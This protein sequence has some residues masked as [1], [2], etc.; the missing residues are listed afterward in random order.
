MTC[1]RSHSTSVAVRPGRRAPVFFHCIEKPMKQLKISTENRQLCSKPATGHRSSH[2][3]DT[4]PLC[5]TGQTEVQRRKRATPFSLPAQV[6][7]Q[8]CAGT[9]PRSS[10]CCPECRLPVPA[11]LL[12]AQDTRPSS[13]RSGLQGVTATAGPPLPD[14][15]GTPRKRPP[16]RMEARESNRHPRSMAQRQGAQQ[17][18]RS[19]TKKTRRWRCHLGEPWQ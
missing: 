19:K 13:Q 2:T 17:R 9:E 4:A 12:C 1:L 15:L 6:T 7:Q 16:Q 8:D 14:I 3:T 11:A 10:T 5:T 18:P